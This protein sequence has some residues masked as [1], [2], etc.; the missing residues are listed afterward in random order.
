MD[1]RSCTVYAEPVTATAR[2]IASEEPGFS[3]AM[4]VYAEKFFG[5][6]YR[7]SQDWVGELDLDLPPPVCPESLPDISPPGGVRPARWA[8]VAEGTA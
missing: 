6:L 7:W 4:R 1:V 2:L 5:E 3:W 8:F